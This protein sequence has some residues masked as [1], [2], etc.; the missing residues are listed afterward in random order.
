MKE[1][2]MSTW[3]SDLVWGSLAATV[4]AYEVY[5]LK[6]DK[7]DHTLTRTTRRTFKTTHPAGKAVFAI[8]WGW[9]ATWF[10]RHI[11]ESPDPIG[12]LIE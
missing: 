1:G 2:S 11:L 7:L 8:G 3:K 12:S 10:M 6:S 9:F 4:I 5:T